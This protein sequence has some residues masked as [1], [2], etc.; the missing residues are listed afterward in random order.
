MEAD[1]EGFGQI[2]A[3]AARSKVEETKKVPKVLR[4][5]KGFELY[6]QCLQILLQKQVWWL[7]KEKGFPEE[8]EVC[9]PSFPCGELELTQ[10]G[11]PGYCA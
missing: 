4:G 2:G 10:K 5:R 6:L 9:D 7:I 1:D 11:G 8:L 3:R